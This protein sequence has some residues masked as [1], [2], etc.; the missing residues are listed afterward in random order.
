MLSVT[1]PVTSLR[2]FKMPLFLAIQIIHLNRFGMV[3]DFII[4]LNICWTENSTSLD[5]FLTERSI[6]TSTN[7]ANKWIRELNFTGLFGETPLLV[8]QGFL[9]R[10][11]DLFHFLIAHLE[12]N[13]LNVTSKILEHSTTNGLNERWSYRDILF[14]SVTHWVFK[15]ILN[16]LYTVS[17]MFK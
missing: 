14:D 5:H 9:M 17:E 15:I 12:R 11:F 13:V 3:N 2:Q 7:W 8:L 16:Y 6:F 10:H 1:V 4:P